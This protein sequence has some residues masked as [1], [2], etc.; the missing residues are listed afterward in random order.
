MPPQQSRQGSRD[1]PKQ[2]CK[3]TSARDYVLWK[4]IAM[5][6]TDLA[7]VHVEYYTHDRQASPLLVECLEREGAGWP[8]RTS[9]LDTTTAPAS[10]HNINIEK[11]P[12]TRPM[13]RTSILASGHQSSGARST[14][15]TTHVH[16]TSI[17]SIFC[18][19]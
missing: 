15:P 19:C 4:V 1:Q 5:P 8:A 18:I 10:R 16:H 17:T 14:L 6:P 11:Q 3:R 7:L 2:Q 9:S 13:M 12:S